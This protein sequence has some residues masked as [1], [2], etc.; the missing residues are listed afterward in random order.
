MIPGSKPKRVWTIGHSKHNLEQ[1]IELLKSNQITALADVRS[2]PVS[3]IAP[4]F[5]EASLK[6][7]L[8]NNR[9]Q[10][11]FLGKELGGRPLD[12]EM[13]DKQGRVYYN[14]LA[15]STLFKSGLARIEK[16]MIE[17]NV[18]IMCSEGKPDGC[19][20]HLLIGRVLN[21][22]GYKVTNIMVDGSLRE[23]SELVPETNQYL[24]PDFGEEESWK[25]ILPVRQES[26]RSDSFYD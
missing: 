19:H 20:R 13:Y 5:N 18:A 11:I 22:L 23:Y 6:V 12:N 16:G 24:L 7:H 14:R 1:F 26:Q 15:N 8:A 25:S 21:N 2:V 4:Q 10:Y 17:F 3:K 9:I